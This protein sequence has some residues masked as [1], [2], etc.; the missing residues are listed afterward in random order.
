MDWMTL[1]LLSLCMVNIKQIKSF[2]AHYIRISRIYYHVLI[3][4]YHLLSLQ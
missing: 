3:V 2:V 1:L 4:T